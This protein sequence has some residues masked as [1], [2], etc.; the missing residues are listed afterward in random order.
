MLYFLKC[1]VLTQKFGTDKKN[2]KYNLYCNDKNDPK[3]LISDGLREEVL[4][5]NSYSNTM[6]DKV[7]VYF[8]GRTPASHSW[9]MPQHQMRT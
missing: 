3:K 2:A 1:T 8:S 4:E 5:N 6:E 9:F 7:G